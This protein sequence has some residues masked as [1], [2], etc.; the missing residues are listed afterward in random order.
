MKKISLSGGRA[1]ALVDDEDYERVIAAGYWKV[2]RKGYARHP[3]RANGTRGSVYL[4]RFILGLPKHS[5]YVDHVNGDPLDNRRCNLRAAN[6]GENSR[7]TRTPKTNTSG[8]K[9]V[10]WNS[11]RGEWEAYVGLNGKKKN[12]GWFKCKL[13]ATIVVCRARETMHGE[14]ANHGGDK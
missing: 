6:P 9:G 7:N 4:H 2:D 1:F 11:R 10:S 3:V 5:P 12:L 8:V 14:F 13:G